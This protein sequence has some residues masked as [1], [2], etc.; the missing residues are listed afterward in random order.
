MKTGKLMV[1]GAGMLLMF[2]L[3]AIAQTATPPPQT[4]STTIYFDWTTNMTNDGYL[5]GT[6]SAKLLSN[7]FA[8]RRAYFT[9]ENKINDD[10]KFRFRIDADNQNN[11]TAVNFKSSSVSQD[12]KLRPFVKALYLDWAGLLPDS[13]LKVGM[14]ET[15]PFKMAEDRW[16]Y[17]SV[18]K[19][20][21]DIY[22]DVTGVNVRCSS[23]DLGAQFSVPVNQYLRLAAMVVNGDGYG[24]PATTKFR[25]FGGQVQLIPV[26]GLNLVGYYEVEDRPAT[27]TMIAAGSKSYDSAGTAKMMKGDVYFDMIENL[28]VSFEWFKYDNPTF[29]YKS[30]ANTIQ[31][32]T[33]GWSVFGS[34]KIILNKLNAFARYDSYAP[35]STQSIKDQGLTIVGLDWAP[36]HSSWKIQPNVWFY[37]YKDAAKK[38]DVVA[39]LTFFLSF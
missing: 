32:K 34:Y 24:S 35:D 30:G 9:Y 6:D 33:G 20:L 36:V 18:A 23:A 1:L 5:T 27:S 11:V 17:R 13:S 12:Y 19:T 16:G 37:N 10:L 38:S 2:G 29:T 3:A 31:Y 25:K 26:A 8:F 15:L 7:K 22:K 4:F 14:I 21:A 28:N 39:N